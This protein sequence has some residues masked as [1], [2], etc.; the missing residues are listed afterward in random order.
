[1]LVVDA[2][3]QSIAYVY[4]RES[5]HDATVGTVLTKDEARRIVRNIAKLP[6]LLKPEGT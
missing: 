3:G 2:N 4:A 6:Q 1:M 5:D